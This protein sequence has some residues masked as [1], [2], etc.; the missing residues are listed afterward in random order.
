MQSVGDTPLTNHLAS[1]M[2]RA[3]V[4]LCWLIPLAYIMS[5]GPDTPVTDGAVTA[6]SLFIPALFAALVW[7]LRPAASVRNST[8]PFAVLW[9]GMTWWLQNRAALEHG[10]AELILSGDIA[11]A[12]LSFIHVSLSVYRGYSSARRPTERMTLGDLLRGTVLT[13]TALLVLRL[14][15]EWY[16]V[17]PVLVLPLAL[18]GSSVSAR[19]YLI[20]PSLDASRLDWRARWA[21]VA[22]LVIIP[23]AATLILIGMSSPGFWSAVASVISGV[24]RYIA[25]AITLLVYPFAYLAYLLYRLLLRFIPEDAEAPP[26]DEPGPPEL[27]EWE[28]VDDAPVAAVL[29]IILRILTVLVMLGVVAWVFRALRGP[30]E[31]PPVEEWEEERV[32]LWDPDAFRRRLREM[33][34]PTADDPET[35][36]YRTDTERRIRTWFREFTTLASPVHRYTS[37]QT[38]RVYC[39][40]VAEKAADLSRRATSGLFELL[41]AYDLVRYGPPVEDDRLQQRAEEAMET[42]LVERW[43]SQGS[44][45]SV[46]ADSGG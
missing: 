46:K 24:W 25:E 12:A 11:P 36:T 20:N 16:P 13:G 33:I 43:A 34:S 39:R 30:Q 45:G 3:T 18:V 15:V 14:S 31:A 10:L 21:V 17:W 37:T 9:I 6:A 26:V 22:A 38:P 23:F 29:S 4:D 27:D 2:L 19:A 41:G 35:P 40:R 8:L 28:I 32:S 44:G 1:T 5:G 42:L 7:H